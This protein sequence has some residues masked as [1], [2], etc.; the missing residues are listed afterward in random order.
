MKS[1]LKYTTFLVAAVIFLFSCEKDDY[2]GDSQLTP[3]NPTIIIGGVDAGGYNF[4]EKDT[5]ISFVVTLSEP[6]VVNVQLTV[7]QIDGNATVLDDY[8]VV[9]SNSEVVIPAYSSG[10]ILSIKIMKDNL[11][12]ETETFTLQIGDQATANANLTP[13][14]AVF[15]IGNHTESSLSTEMSW[16]T[17]VLDVIGVDLD[18][19][20]VVDLRMLV[21]DNSSGEIV[22]VEDGG[23]FETYSAWDTLP[24]GTYLI[25]TDIFSTIYAGDLNEIVDLS[26]SLNFNQPGT[27]NDMTLDFNNVMTNFYACDLY[28]TYLATVVKSGESFTIEKSI[29]QAVTAD[30][31]ILVGS[32]VGD[33]SELGYESLADVFVRNDSLFIDSLGYGWMTDFWGEVVTDGG[34]AYFE[35]NWCTGEVTIPQ[36]YYMT[37]TYEGDPQTPYDLVGEGLIDFS[38]DYPTMIVRYD[39]VQAGTSWGTWMFDNGY[40]STEYFEARITL[41]PAGLPVT[42]AK[43]LKKKALIQKPVR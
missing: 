42:A 38:G 37:T 21:I 41:D 11:A 8:A 43:T 15:T 22:A 20:A 39:F 4:V 30:L 35:V 7:K 36:Q 33:D 10:G 6:Q 14:Q 2:T 19:D 16:S 29:S 26:L 12:E 40:M 27:I 1:I 25:A 34:N 9:N 5:V 31:D 18:P 13:V 24:D 17:N 28:R 23:S 32:W 3:T